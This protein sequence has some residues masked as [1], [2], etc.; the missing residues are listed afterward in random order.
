MGCGPACI[1]EGTDRDIT[2]V[3]F[4]ESAIK[5]A[6]NNVPNGNFLVSD[7][8][9]TPLSGVFDTIV[10]CGVVNYFP[11]LTPLR[12]EVL[13]LSTNI[14]RVL[15]TINDMR[16]L[17]ERFWDLEEVG[18]EFNQ[19]GVIEEASFHEGIGWLIVVVV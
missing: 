16:G 5:E 7:I 17:N 3:D 13:R 8:T 11:D 1:W 2:G 18:K 10:L 14:T 15:I 6:K 12:K 4:S 19:W 9:V